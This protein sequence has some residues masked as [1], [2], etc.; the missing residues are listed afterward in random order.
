MRGGV[1]LQM[2]GV[3]SE[4]GEVMD[5]EWIKSWPIS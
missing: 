4:G 2:A 3:F 5:R 1:H